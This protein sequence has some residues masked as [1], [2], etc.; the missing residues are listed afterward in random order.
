MTTLFL[1]QAQIVEAFPAADLSAAASTGDWV[2][3]RNYRHVAVVFHSEPGTAADD[4]TITIQQATDNAASGAKSLTF[5]T[6][7]SKQAATSLAS[8]AQ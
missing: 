1:E 6:L 4:P 5:T 7:Y 2:S 8:T 3:L